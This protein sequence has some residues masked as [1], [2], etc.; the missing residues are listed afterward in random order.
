MSHPSLRFVARL[1]FLVIVA[2]IVS[3]LLVIM[4]CTVPTSSAMTAHASS[5]AQTIAGSVLLVVSHQSG[6]TTSGSNV[7]YSTTGLILTGTNT[8]SGST[9]TYV[10][11][12]TLSNYT[13]AATGYTASGTV[14]WSQTNTSTAE[15]GTIPET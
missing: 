10:L 8:T 5:A 7:S 3:T 13:D 11:T 14:N 1:S 4:G 2:S 9:S 15:P 12:I 6:W